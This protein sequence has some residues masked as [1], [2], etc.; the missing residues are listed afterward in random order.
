MTKT[1]DLFLCGYALMRAKEK[2]KLRLVRANSMDPMQVRP[3]SPLHVS[4]VE[5]NVLARYLA[6][7]EAK[8]AVRR[9]GGKPQYMDTRELGELARA[10][11]EEHRAQLMERACDRLLDRRN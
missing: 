1:D 4:R 7:G 8:E 10:F 11:F 9:Q 2:P 5:V 6:L 3:W